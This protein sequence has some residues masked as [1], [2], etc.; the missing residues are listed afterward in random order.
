MGNQY[1]DFIYTTLM[2]NRESAAVAGA[3]APVPSAVVLSL[4]FEKFMA[5]AAARDLT[6]NKAKLTSDDRGP[7][8]PAL[9]F[10]ECGN[11]D[12]LQEKR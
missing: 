2:D 9:P 7:A 4:A 3:A 5:E 1:S 6:L 12:S 8:D 11:L 10:A